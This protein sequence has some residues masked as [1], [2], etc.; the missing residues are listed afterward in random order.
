MGSNRHVGSVRFD[1]GV[2]QAVSKV[3]G[4]FYLLFPSPHLQLCLGREYLMTWRKIAYIPG[5][6]T[7]TDVPNVAG[8]SKTCE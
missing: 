6:A 7:I 3:A 2:Q 8:V 5:T 1:A 4:Q